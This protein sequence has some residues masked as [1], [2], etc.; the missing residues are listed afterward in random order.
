MGDHSFREFLKT[1]YIPAGLHFDSAKSYSLFAVIFFSALLL[2]VALEGKDY[3][4]RG[5]RSWLAG[6]TSGLPFF[7]FSYTFLWFLASEPTS[8]NVLTVLFP[9]LLFG[10]LSFLLFLRARDLARRGMSEEQLW[11]PLVKRQATQIKVH[12]SDEPIETWEEDMLG[13]AALV[14]SISVKLL[15]SKSPV[16]GLFAPYGAGK[17]SVLNLLHE[18]LKDKA[19][20]V[21]FSTWL[22]GSQTTLTA[23][24]LGDIAS[25]VQKQYVVPGLRRSVRRVTSALGK[26]VPLLQ[27]VTEAMPAKTQKEDIDDLQMALM[28]LPKRVVV[29]LDEI[30]RMERKELITLLKIIRGIS[31]LPNLSF[32]CA[33]DLKAIIK[34]VK[35]TEDESSYHYFEKFFPVAINVPEPDPD[36]LATA[37]AERLVEA[38][39]QREWF[40]TASEENDFRKSIEEIWHKRI[41]PFCPN[42][43]AI[44]LLANDVSVA[45]APLRRE[46][47][48]VDL[49]LVRLLQRFQPQAHQL[50]SHSSEVLT[51]G[52]SVLR[53]GRYMTERQR[54][55]A[56]Q[57]FLKDLEDAVS[58]QNVENVKNLLREMFPEF[59]KVE[60]QAWRNL[61]KRTNGDKENNKH[62]SHAGIF[63]AYFRHEIPKAIFSSVELDGLLHRIE[64]EPDEGTRCRI[65]MDVLQSMEPGSLKRDDFLRKLAEASRSLST[66]LGKSIAHAIALNADKLVYDMFSGFG[67]AGHAVRIILRVCETANRD[68]RLELITNLIKEADDDTMAVRILE[69]SRKNR[70]GV[71]LK[72]SYADLYRAFTERMRTRYGRNVDAPNVDLRLTDPIAFSMWTD[73]HPQENVTVDP[74]DRLIQQD[75]WIRHIGNSRG[76][77]ARTFR[78]IL[79]PSNVRFESDPSP[80]IDKKIPLTKL[81]ELYEQLPKDDPDL[82]QE[83]QVSLRVLDRFLAGEFKGGTPMGTLY[84][85]EMTTPEG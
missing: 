82:T 62:I 22:P 67:E 75:F 1:T 59:A 43:R 50:I 5:L 34:T 73:P 21:P 85:E 32:V 78:K 11:V 28:R 51:G 36:A 54:S 40:E 14:D 25:G 74:E 16:I 76:R 60:A 42:L 13:R 6:V 24:L 19:I 18:H 58:P 31:T 63:P 30:D 38:F 4:W 66:S 72:V 79:L 48:P 12:D 80:W 53:S 49:V 41:A 77:L 23:Y 29:L 56:Q 64:S 83:D 39:K 44:G 17:T 35:K 52:D 20:V 68:E 61:L 3:I 47:D 46:V 45:A 10:F 57:R 37:G 7:T 2:A 26:T 81:R 69:A 33:A 71:D 9:V 27:A 55:E 65:F 70:V 84:Q 8:R 15:I